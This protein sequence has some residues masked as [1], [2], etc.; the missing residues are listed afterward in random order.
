ME[1]FFESGRAIDVIL[2]IMLLEMLV[3]IARKRGDTVSIVLAILPGMLILL[4]LRGVITGAPWPL[5]AA[6]L[7]GS[8]PIHL[9]DIRRRRW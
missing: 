5:V 1:A 8:W 9:A 7:L 3:L 2:A 4:A 6:L